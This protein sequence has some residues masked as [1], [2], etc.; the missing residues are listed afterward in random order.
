L[1]DLACWRAIASRALYGRIA[2]APAGALELIN[3]DGN[4]KI[5]ENQRE[6]SENQREKA[7]R[8]INAKC[9]K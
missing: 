3:G 1:P 6:I 5:S 8:T 2:Y 4:N 7:V 9:N